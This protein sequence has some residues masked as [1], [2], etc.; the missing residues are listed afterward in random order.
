M[1]LAGPQMVTLEDIRMATDKAPSKA[2]FLAALKENGINSLEDLADAI[3]PEVDETG[4][5]LFNMDTG[6]SLA[7]GESANLG[8]T[9]HGRDVAGFIANWRSQYGE[10]YP[11]T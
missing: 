8:F 2:E 4:G 6:A 5:Y 7:V 3:M 9:S 1:E 11:D 10:V